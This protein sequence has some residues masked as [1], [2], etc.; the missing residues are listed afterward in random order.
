MCHNKYDDQ[1]K[2]SYLFFLFLQI[3]LS[4]LI[5]N[6]SK[7]FIFLREEKKKKPKWCLCGCTCLFT[8]CHH[9]P[10]IN[11]IVCP[12]TQFPGNTH[13]ELIQV[14]FL[15]HLWSLG[16]CIKWLL[17]TFHKYQDYACLREISKCY[18]YTS[19]FSWD[20]TMLS[21]EPSTEVTTV[22][23]NAIGWVFL[24]Y[25]NRAEKIYSQGFLT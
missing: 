23:L 15:C 1:R 17:A 16:S 13:L 24:C 2:Q 5:Q 19:F 3:F 25:A 21:K 10:G 8:Q 6:T 9:F 18:V 12:W 22:S 20:F 7:P 4:V 11:T 14:N